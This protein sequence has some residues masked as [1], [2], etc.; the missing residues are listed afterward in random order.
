MFLLDTNALS[1]PLRVRP[2]PKFVAELERAAVRT[3]YTSAVCA[4]E[5][6]YGCAR[7]GDASLWKRIEREILSRIEILPF[8]PREA[9]I[10]GDLLAEMQRSGRPVS[11]E[12][13][14]IAATA[15]ARELIVVTANVDYFSRIPAL[16]VVNWMK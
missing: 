14:Q 6:R 7:K 4:M 2:R 9:E 1:E 3:L 10:A 15:L 8:G 12:D 16:A 11:I 5:L 13:L